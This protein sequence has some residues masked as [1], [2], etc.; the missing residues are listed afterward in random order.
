MALA[1]GFHQNRLLKILNKIVRKWHFFAELCIF[2]IFLA[3][4][5][6]EKVLLLGGRM[7]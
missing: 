1:A 6:G 5:D 7:W 4:N 2:Y 3:E